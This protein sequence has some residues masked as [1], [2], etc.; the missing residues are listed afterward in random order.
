MIKIAGAMVTAIIMLSWVLYAQIGKTAETKAALDAFQK[1]LAVQL[2]ENHRVNKLLIEHQRAEQ[3]ERVKTQAARREA[4]NAINTKPKDDCVNAV[5]PD[6][7]R[8]LINSN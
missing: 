7:L 3:A 1:E 6:D 8:V 5:I 2:D 4:N